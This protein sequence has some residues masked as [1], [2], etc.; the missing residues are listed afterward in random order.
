MGCASEDSKDSDS[1]ASGGSDATHLGGSSGKSSSGNSGGSKANSSTASGGAEQQKSTVEV[2]GSGGG[3]SIASHSGT[4]AGGNSSASSSSLSASGGSAGAVSSTL[5]STA[6]PATAEGAF[7]CPS[8]GSSATKLYPDAKSVTTSQGSSFIPDRTGGSLSDG[9]YYLVE[10]TMRNSGRV[11]RSESGAIEIKG[12][13]IKIVISRIT[14]PTDSA[15]VG[16]FT[17]SGKTLDL[18]GVKPC[19]GGEG[20][21]IAGEL[22]DYSATS[23]SLTFMVGPVEY[24]FEKQ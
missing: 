5:A 4:Q 9:T 24:L 18:K 21:N 12:S 11:P 16:T 2:G 15:W 17:T 3:S 23:T 13:S 14:E 7:T 8:D 1:G 20:A 22:F 19:Y 10:R 6:P